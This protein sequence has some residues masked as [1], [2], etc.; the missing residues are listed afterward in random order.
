MLLHGTI[1][2]FKALKTKKPIERNAEIVCSFFW[3]S[4]RIGNRIW[5]VCAGAH[6]AIRSCY[7]SFCFYCSICRHCYI[8]LCTFHSCQDKQV[9]LSDDKMQ[10]K[11][12]HTHSTQIVRYWIHLTRTLNINCQL[13]AYNTNTFQ[14]WRLIGWCVLLAVDLRDHFSKFSH[15]LWSK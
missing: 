13:Y 5:I 10:Q 11:C 4:A 1:A 7:N 14:P 6:V 12:K 15:S 8:P 2:C 3:V 9:G